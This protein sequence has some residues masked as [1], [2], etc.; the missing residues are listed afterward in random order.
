MCDI[1]KTIEQIDFQVV[2][3]EV[4]TIISITF[5]EHYQFGSYLTT[6]YMDVTSTPNVAYIKPRVFSFTSL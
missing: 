3:S 5:L 4:S 2:E 1:D 6:W